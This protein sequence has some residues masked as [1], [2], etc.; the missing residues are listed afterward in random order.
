MAAESVINTILVI[1]ATGSILKAL[2]AALSPD[3]AGQFDAVEDS[4]NMLLEEEPQHVLDDLHTIARK[5]G[6]SA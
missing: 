5:A 3:I 6:T 4:R 1:G 2:F